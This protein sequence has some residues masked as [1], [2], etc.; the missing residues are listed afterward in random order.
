[1]KSTGILKDVTFDVKVEDS[2]N[3][4]CILRRMQTE[5]RNDLL[6]GGAQIH[7]PGYINEPGVQQIF[8]VRMWVEA[9]P[10]SWWRTLIGRVPTVHKV[11]I[12]IAQAH[13]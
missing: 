13:Q 12:A 9:L 4:Y 6:L 10:C 11:R 8:G 5:L 1:M 2:L 3:V 7:I